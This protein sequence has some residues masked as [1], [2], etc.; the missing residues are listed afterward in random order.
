MSQKSAIPTACLCALD[1]PNGRFCV[2]SISSLI[3]T[4]VA[5]ALAADTSDEDNQLTRCF[6]KNASVSPKTQAAAIKRA[7][8]IRLALSITNQPNRITR[9]V[10]AENEPPSFHDFFPD[11]NR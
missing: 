6:D 5:E 8:Y 2:V 9:D 4:D 10:A 3:A 1:C 7:A 11:E